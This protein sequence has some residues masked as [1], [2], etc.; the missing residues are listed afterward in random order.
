[1]RSGSGEIQTGE[2]GVG[3]REKK[4][5]EKNSSQE[6]KITTVNTL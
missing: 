4:F 6:K 5:R 3:A 2:D 1:M